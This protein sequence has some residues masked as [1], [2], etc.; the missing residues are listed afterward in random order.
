MSMKKWIMKQYWRVSA[1]RAITSLA[2]GMF[3]LGR[4]YYEY[5]PILQDMGF[6]GA[7]ILGTVLF[8]LFMGLGWIYD[9][10]GRMWSPQAQA[11]VERS[12]FSYV[13][14]YRSYAVDY[15]VFYSILKTLKRIECKLGLGTE[16]T[17]DVLMYLD[18]FFQRG[19][20]RKDIS[21]ALRDATDFMQDHPF[22]QQSDVAERTPSLGGKTK[23]SFQVQMLRLTW[24]QSLTGLLQ[25]VLIFGTFVITLVY[26][27]GSDVIGEVVPLE[28][29][30]LGF[31]VISLPLFVLLAVLGW[32]YDRKLQIWTP[33]LMVQVERN[34]FTY[35]AEPRLHIL[36][37]PAL[38]VVLETLRQVLLSLGEETSEVERILTYIK[39]YSKLDVTRDEDMEHARNLRKSLG[40][41]FKAE[42]GRV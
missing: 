18:G 12:P 22:T 16:S 31:F 6:V 15:A 35:V 7:L 42:E 17:D 11:T 8:L 33:D 25:D 41:L 19:I 27:E 1:I 38:I 5:I 40:V 20:N 24:I 4:L 3:V 13:A 23:L 2:L 29:L 28:I 26:F 32:F 9:V 21:S 34:P 37:L 30:I 36:I 14:D 10:K 39:E